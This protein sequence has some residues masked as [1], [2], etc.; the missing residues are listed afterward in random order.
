M[1]WRF[2]ALAACCFLAAACLNPVASWNQDGGE[3]DTPADGGQDAG[4]DGGADAGSP[5]GGRSGEYSAC[6][7]IGALDRI[8]ISRT[9]LARGTRVRLILVS[10]AT[11]GPLGITVP[12]GWGGQNA[13]LETATTSVQATS[14]SGEVRF[15]QA[16]GGLWPYP[17]SLDVHLSLS[18]PGVGTERLDSDGLPLSGDCLYS[19]L[20]GRWISVTGTGALTANDLKGVWATSPGQAWAVGKRNTALGWDGARWTVGYS[21]TAALVDYEGV[22]ASGPADYWLVGNHSSGMILHLTGGFWQP[23]MFSNPSAHRLNAIWGSRASDIW[24]VGG[25]TFAGAAWRWNGSSWSSFNTQAGRPLTAIAGL[26]STDVWTIV[27]PGSLSRY[28]GAKWTLYP[29]P[30]GALTGGL[31]VRS[32]SPVDVWATGASGKLYHFDGSAWTTAYSGSNTLSDIWASGANDAWAVGAGGA[33]AHF[34]GISWRGLPSPTTADLHSVHGTG[35]ADVWAVGNAGTMLHF[36]EGTKGA[37]CNGDWTCN[38]GLLCCFPYPSCGAP[39]CHNRCSVPLDGGLGCPS[40][41]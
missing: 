41:L 11:G 7:Y 26:S 32:S 25:S 28:D 16:D 36:G 27:E 3:G 35:E 8:A 15:R 19:N 2:A 5:D 31:W 21:M 38:S 39:G 22:W 10:P 37:L 24:A 18:F 30:P 4:R 29:L 20:K 6:A 40:E 14:G 33:L 9:N 23:S 1:R 34:D 17:E 13:V 12:P